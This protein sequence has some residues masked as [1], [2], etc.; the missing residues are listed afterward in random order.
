MLEFS[1]YF[2]MFYFKFSLIDTYS[3]YL[4]SDFFF[5][6]FFFFLVSTYLNNE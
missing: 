3:V 6:V 2:D 1:L 4:L 5:A